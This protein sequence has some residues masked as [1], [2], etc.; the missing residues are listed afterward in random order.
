M[1]FQLPKSWRPFVS[2][3]PHGVGIRVFKGFVQINGGSAPECF[4]S[5]V[6]F[7]A[8]IG[9]GRPPEIFMAVLRSVS[10]P[11]RCFGRWVSVV[12]GAL[13]ET[14]GQVEPRVYVARGE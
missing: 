6:E 9:K 10:H 1:G 5:A 2:D 8:V 12:N 14:S 3:G 7:C 11:D 13:V 4:Q